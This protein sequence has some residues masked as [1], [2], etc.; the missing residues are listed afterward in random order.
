[1]T[2]LLLVRRGADADRNLFGAVFE[3]EKSPTAIATRYDDIFGLAGRSACDVRRRAR[4]IGQL[5]PVR[6]RRVAS[7]MV[8]VTAKVAL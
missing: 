1:M 7:S 8:I 3:A 5:T 2:E 6:D 4:G